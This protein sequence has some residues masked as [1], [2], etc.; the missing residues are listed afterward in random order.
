VSREL[1]NKNG[2]T[3]VLFKKRPFSVPKSRGL[4]LLWK[5]F[6][7]KSRGSSNKKAGNYGRGN[8]IRQRELPINPLYIS[9]YLCND[10]ELNQ[11]YIDYENHL[12]IH[13]LDCLLYLDRDY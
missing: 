10:F 5:I 1:L 8:R 3:G 2:K 12:R 4:K 6:L 11:F 7:K 13:P 9:T